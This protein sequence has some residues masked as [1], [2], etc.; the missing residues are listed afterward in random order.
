[1]F[2]PTTV[3]NRYIYLMPKKDDD[4]HRIYENGIH[5]VNTND[6]DAMP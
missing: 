3:K 4:N 1:M 2:F 5:Y 6:Q